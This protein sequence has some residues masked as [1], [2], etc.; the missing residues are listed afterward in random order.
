MAYQYL[1]DNRYRCETCGPLGLQLALQYD[2]KTGDYRLVEKKSI[3][4]WVS[5][6]LSEWCMV[7]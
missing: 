4:N 1:N 6:I 7:L 2:P 3:G 5:S